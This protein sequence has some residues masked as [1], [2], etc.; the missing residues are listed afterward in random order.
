[1]EFLGHHFLVRFYEVKELRKKTI[2]EF[3]RHFMLKHFY[4]MAA[5]VNRFL[6]VHFYYLTL[7][8]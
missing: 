3:I 8:S 5:Q 4:K 6:N 7:L 2:N 1:M